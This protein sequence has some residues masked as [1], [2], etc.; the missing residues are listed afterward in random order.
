[1]EEKVF[2]TLK[3][4]EDWDL[5]FTK[6]KG[7]IIDLGCGY[8]ADSYFL[9]KKGYEV[10]AV[11]EENNLKFKHHNLKFH[12]QKIEELVN[13]HFDGVIANFSLHFLRPKARLETISHYLKSLNPAATIYILIPAKCSTPPFL[14]LFPAKPEIDY[15]DLDDDHPPYGKH[16]H[17]MA[18][19]VYQKL[20]INEKASLATISKQVEKANGRLL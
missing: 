19:V 2:S 8:G 9:A 4:R 13:N 5:Y 20:S 16:T 10:M 17:R 1:M 12:Q 3:P 18:K 7:L 14:E 15:F 6:N 11:D